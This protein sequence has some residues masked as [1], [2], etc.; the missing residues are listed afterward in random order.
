MQFPNETLFRRGCPRKGTTVSNSM[1]KFF[2]FFLERFRPG[3]GIALREAREKTELKD[4]GRDKNKQ[5]VMMHGCDVLADWLLWL[6][7][8]RKRHF[9]QCS[10]PICQMAGRFS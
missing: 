9:C 6:S 10:G 8:C 2:P 3:Y 5:V 4:L 1:N 7:L